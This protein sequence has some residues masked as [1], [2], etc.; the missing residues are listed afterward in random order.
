MEVGWG[1]SGGR[2]RSEARGWGVEE[3]DEGGGLGGREMRQRRRALSEE[4]EKSV[5]P[6]WVFSGSEGSEVDHDSG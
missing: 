4:A 2:G 6:F 3:V 5:S 1:V